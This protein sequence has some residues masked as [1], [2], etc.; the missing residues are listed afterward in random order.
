MCRLHI[1]NFMLTLRKP[2]VLRWMSIE[3]IAARF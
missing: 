1:Q 2:T 3:R